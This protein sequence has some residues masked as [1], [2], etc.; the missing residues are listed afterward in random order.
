MLSASRKFRDY[1]LTM[2]NVNAHYLYLN[3]NDVTA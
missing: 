2:P 3:N 1:F